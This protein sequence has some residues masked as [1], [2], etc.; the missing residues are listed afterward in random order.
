MNV[1]MCNLRYY[2]YIQAL[3][4]LSYSDTYQTMVGGNPHTIA[5][6]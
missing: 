4:C 5:G 3:A 6:I 2:I 1:N